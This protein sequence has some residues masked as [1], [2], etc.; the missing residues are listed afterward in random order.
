MHPAAYEDCRKFVDKYL[1][2]KKPLRI[3]D[4]GSCTIAGQEEGCLR[5]LFDSPHWNYQGLDIEAGPNVDFVVQEY[6]WSNVE[7]NAFD[8]VISS[9]VA[10]HVRHPWRWIKCVASLAKVGAFIYI[11]TPNTIEYHP[12]PVDCWRV[13]P[14][15]LVALFEEAELNMIL[16]CY[17]CNGDTTGIT[18]K[19]KKP[20][21]ER[22]LRAYH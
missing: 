10:E 7:Q 21:E 18:V 1:D 17:A 8:V 15:G 19:T 6:D 9:Q 11:C 13:W 14:D 5:Q 12:Y 2:K 16:E 22:P 3:I 4:V 20:S